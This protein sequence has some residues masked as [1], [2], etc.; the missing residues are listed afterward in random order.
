[1]VI[2]KFGNVFNHSLD[3][4]TDCESTSVKT[5]TQTRLDSDL[6]VA[7]MYREFKANNPTTTVRY[8][9]YVKV[10]KTLNIPTSDSLQSPALSDQGFRQ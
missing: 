4:V 9:T 7:T 2:R 6:Y 8:H 3:A 10:L 5:D 1:V